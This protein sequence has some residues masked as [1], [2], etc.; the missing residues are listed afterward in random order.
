ML[1]TSGQIGSEVALPSVIGQ[2]QAF[3]CRCIHA[4]ACIPLAALCTMHTC[5]LGLSSSSFI[6]AAYKTKLRTYQR[7]RWLCATVQYVIACAHRGAKTTCMVTTFL[8]TEAPIFG[9]LGPRTA[10]E[11]LP[12]TL[13]A[14][15]LLDT[16]VSRDEEGPFNRI[17]LV[18]HS[19]GSSR[20][21]TVYVPLLSSPTCGWSV[22][23]TAVLPS[24]A[25]Q[26]VPLEGFELSRLCS[27]SEVDTRQRRTANVTLTSCSIW[28][29]SRT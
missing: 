12:T 4:R 7:P 18:I 11:P 13:F 10:R 20:I 1:Y 19:R 21:Q 15:F 29:Q 9:I 14:S 26:Q 27:A 16:G 24:L 28:A 25:A 6:K 22:K 5:H 23:E 8:H 3:S 2:A 17:T